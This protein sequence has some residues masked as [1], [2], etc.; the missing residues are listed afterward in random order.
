MMIAIL[1]GVIIADNLVNPQT[2]VTWIKSD[3]NIIQVTQPL[4]TLLQ[5]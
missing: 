5:I 2:P 1:E 3:P 4:S